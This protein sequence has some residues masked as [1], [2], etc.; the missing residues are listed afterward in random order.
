M[1]MSVC[2]WRLGSGVVCVRVCLCL[3]D[4]R[5]EYCLELAYSSCQ[6]RYGLDLM[7]LRRS[8][9]SSV[10][11]NN[12]SCCETLTASCLVSPVFM[13]YAVFFLSL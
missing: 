12:D 7:P 5:Q 9:L 6:R 1:C 11:T 2:E 10:V 4:Q 3:C 13:R 8:P